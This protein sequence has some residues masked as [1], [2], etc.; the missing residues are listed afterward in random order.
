VG[1]APTAATSTITPNKPRFMD[2][3]LTGRAETGA[4]RCDDASLFEK[5]VEKECRNEPDEK[6]DY[7]DNIVEKIRY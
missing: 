7:V 6:K 3:T 5:D 4:R 1:D 2:I